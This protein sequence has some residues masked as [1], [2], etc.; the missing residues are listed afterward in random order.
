[1]NGTYLRGEIYWLEAGVISYPEGRLMDKRRPVVIVSNNKGNERA[2]AVNV[3]F[4]TT[5]EGA[6]G[7]DKVFTWASKPRKSWVM[8]TQ[9]FCVNKEYLTDYVGQLSPREMSSVDANLRE[10]LALERGEAPADKIAI[11]SRDEIIKTK[12]EE[13][14]IQ[15]ERLSAYEADVKRLTEEIESLKLDMQDLSDNHRYEVDL[16]QRMYSKA[17]D[18]VVN[19]QLERDVLRRT[20]LRC[21]NVDKPVVTEVTKVEEPPVKLEEPQKVDEPKPEVEEKPKKPRKPRKKKEPV[22]E[23]LEMEVI[24]ELKPAVSGKVNVNTATAVEIKEAT[25]MSMTVAF[26]ITGY[27]KKHGDYKSLED[28]TKVQRFSESMLAR[29]RDKLEV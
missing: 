29:Y 11:A 1:M 17:V 12:E 13:L 26:C 22:V 20:E 24:E 21:G 9:V 16:W 8:C 7:H 4:M 5:Q 2:D 15:G 3:L 6:G 10:F 28:L 27:R 19:M 18:S 25:G 23:Q 14:R